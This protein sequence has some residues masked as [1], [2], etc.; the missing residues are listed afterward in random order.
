MILLRSNPLAGGA[1]TSG[2]EMQLQLGAHPAL[3]AS[4]SSS[5]QT[6]FAARSGYKVDFNAA[7]SD[8]T[9]SWFG[10]QKETAATQ[11]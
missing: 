3:S 7:D 11:S 4:L 8:P 2:N 10:W 5:E 9:L 6:I 1:L